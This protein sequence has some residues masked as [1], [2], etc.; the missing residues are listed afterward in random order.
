MSIKRN[1]PARVPG[2]MC[3]HCQTRSIAY[4]S[5]EID[6][7]TREIRFVCQNADCGHTFVAQ[8]AIFRTVRP[9]LIPNPAVI[10]PFGQW[11][12]KPA[13]DD[14]QTPGNDNQVPAAETAP[15]PS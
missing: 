7:L 1:Y 9:S 13:N 4:D 6:P 11:R 14:E 2:I 5:V 3:P 12:S 15:T 10:L 8:L